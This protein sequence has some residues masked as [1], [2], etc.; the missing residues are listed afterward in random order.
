MWVALHWIGDQENQEM[1][2]MQLLT[3]PCGMKTYWF[4]PPASIF[5]LACHYILIP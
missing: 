3:L 1:G 5:M 2:E 4:K